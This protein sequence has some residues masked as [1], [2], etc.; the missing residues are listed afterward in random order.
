MGRMK[1]IKPPALGPGA[2]LAIVTNASA[3]TASEEAVE[4]GYARLRARGFE[5]V[6][7]ANC[8]TEV[9]HTAGTIRERV[10]ALHA[11]FRSRKIDGILNFWGGYQSHQLLEH[12]DLDL[13]RRRP[14]A[15]IGYSDTT[16]LQV[17]LLARVGL[18]SFSG[19]AGISFA[20]PTVP[21]FTWEHFERVL[22]RGE[23]GVALGAAAEFSDNPWFKDPEGKMRF[24]A[25]PGWKIYRGGEARGPI[26]G[27]NLGTMLLLAGTPY[28][29]KLKGAVL[30]VEEDE[31]ERPET[32]DRMFT[33]LRHMGVYDQIAGMVVGRFS[34]AVG[35]K[36][37][38]TLEK[39]LDDALRGHRF[40]VILD[41]DFGH[42]DPLL[43]IPLGV[44]CRVST[45]KPEILL[46]EAAVTRG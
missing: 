37:G 31:S 2:R 15:F 13:I 30:F 28:W 10:K 25:N 29:P 44:R 42:T 45:K 21:D 38:D 34:R 32:V 19:P 46:E 23:A 9:G 43:T 5:V 3:L 22:V 16:A 6:E 12:L 11:C 26:V 35:F 36:D 20:K 33:Q 14:K 7:A 4:R 18:V 8:R 17:A 24:E 41:A 1:L 40:P 27:G 39:I